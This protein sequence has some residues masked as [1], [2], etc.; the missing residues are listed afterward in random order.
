MKRMYMV[1]YFDY[2]NDTYTTY[3]QAENMEDLILNLKDYLDS[4][5]F[6]Y[7]I[8]LIFSEEKEL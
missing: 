3:I 2:Y 4:D 6:I 5:C 1:D 8:E 7:K